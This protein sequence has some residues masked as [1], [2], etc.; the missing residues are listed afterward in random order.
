L[1]FIG[2]GKSRWEEFKMPA[3]GSSTIYSVKNGAQHTVGARARKFCVKVKC[4]KR[5]CV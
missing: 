1:K 5:E 2:S 4:L 3:L